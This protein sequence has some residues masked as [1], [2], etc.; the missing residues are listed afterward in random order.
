VIRVAVAN[1][2]IA[3]AVVLA[4][5]VG[6]GGCLP[7]RQALMAPVPALDLA[8]TAS[9]VVVFVR[10]SSPCD[11]GEAFRLVDESA[12]FLGDSPPASKFAARFPAG[13]HAFFA[14]QPSGD[15]P[16]DQFPFVNQVGAVEADLAAGQ[17]YYVTV[18]IANDRYSLRKTCSNYQWLALRFADPEQPDLQRTLADA[19]AWVPDAPAGQRVVDADRVDALRHIELGKRKLRRP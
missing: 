14:W 15:L 6:A 7:P 3:S 9:A 2:A 19:Q 18:A 4:S 11:G 12:R 10:E 17:V 16:P 13:R 8:P 1:A 5:S